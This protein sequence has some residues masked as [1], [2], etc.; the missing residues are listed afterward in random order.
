MTRQECPL[1]QTLT[2]FHH[3]LWGKPVRPVRSVMALGTL[4]AREM[5]NTKARLQ[6]CPSPASPTT[7]HLVDKPSLWAPASHLANERT[8][9]GSKL[10]L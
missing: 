4:Q 1:L 5:G 2:K 8:G 3:S 6:S 10:W 9:L 7:S